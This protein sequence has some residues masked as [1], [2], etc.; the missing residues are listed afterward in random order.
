VLA[1]GEEEVACLGVTS[2]ENPLEVT[3]ETLFQ[4]GSIGKTYVAAAAMRLVE[5]GKL[6]LDEPVRTYLPDLRLADSG[7]AERVTLR[8]LLTHTGGWVGDYFDDLGLGDDALARG[9]ERMANLDQ[10]TPL[11]EVWAY[12]NAGF[13][14]AGRVLEVATGRPFETALHELVLEPL[15]LERSFFFPHEVIT[16]RFAVGHVLGE[17]EKAA[18]SREWWI[19][20]VAHAAGGIVCSLEDLLRYARFAFDGAPL[21]RRESFAELRRPQFPV[22]GDVDAVGLAWMLREVEGVQLMAHDGG[23]SGQISTLVVAPDRRFAFACLTNH[24]HGGRL[25]QRL[26]N[27]VLEAYLGVSEPAPE[28]VEVKPERLAEYAGRYSAAMADLEVAVVDGGLEARATMKGGF[29]RPD[30]PPP[31]PPPPATFLFCGED[32]VFCPEGFWEGLRAQ[33]L[34]GPDGE[35]AWLRLG[36]RIYRPERRA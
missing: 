13:Y 12:N 32:D 26:T 28:A 24:Q 34:R 21:L 19:G 27:P 9:V 30:S 17:N 8:H 31:P 35:I 1:D 6:A 29:P 36:G 5:E 20:R 2:I 7:A 33:F 3:P 11:G 16:H 25:M 4:I 15:G 23:T 18:V 22:G 14:L 10:L